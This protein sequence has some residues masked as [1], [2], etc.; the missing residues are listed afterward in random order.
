MFVELDMMLVTMRASDT[1]S[2]VENKGSLYNIYI[3]SNDIC[4]GY[5]QMLQMW[6]FGTIF[7]TELQLLQ[8][9]E[10]CLSTKDSYIY[11]DA[12]GSVV[13][14]LPDQKKTLF[15]SDMF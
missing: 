14:P 9:I 2:K 3:F 12:T 13:K 4:K 7:Y 8:F 6:P 11:I 5:I 1:D 15:I 10:Y